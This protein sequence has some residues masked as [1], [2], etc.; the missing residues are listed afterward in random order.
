VRQGQPVDQILNH[1]ASTEQDLLMLCSPGNTS[2]ENAWRDAVTY[3]TIAGARC[4]VVIAGDRSD[5]AVAFNIPATSAPQRFSP[6]GE[7]FTD[8]HRKEALK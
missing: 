1:C 3:R 5:A 7:H 2:S 8:E 4:P 6:Q